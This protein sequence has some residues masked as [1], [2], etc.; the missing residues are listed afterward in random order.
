M[1]KRRF[2]M[3]FM[4]NVNMTHEI[5]FKVNHFLIINKDKLKL[6]TKNILNRFR[7]SA[8]MS[9]PAAVHSKMTL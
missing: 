8:E 5:R 6:F 1:P 2:F 3:P 9:I 4:A 7:S